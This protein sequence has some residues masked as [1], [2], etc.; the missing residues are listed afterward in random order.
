MYERGVLA[1]PV[2]YFVY[3]DL[4]QFVTLHFDLVLIWNVNA[5]EK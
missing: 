2:A 3:Q 4:F 5:A 1:K